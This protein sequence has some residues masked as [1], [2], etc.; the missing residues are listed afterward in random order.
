YLEPRPVPEGG[1]RGFLSLQRS[2]LR[3]KTT[4]RD[5]SL[6]AGHLHKTK[7]P[8]P[9]A[10]LV[11]IN[12]AK[13]YAKP[14]NFFAFSRNGSSSGVISYSSMIASTGHTVTHAPQS[15]QISGSI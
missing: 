13:Y 15:M 8:N 2:Y 7:K 4:A 10:G 1:R 11:N 5:T 3:D 12:S 6:H 9:F 14:Y